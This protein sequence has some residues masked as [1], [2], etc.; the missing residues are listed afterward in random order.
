MAQSDLSGSAEDAAAE[1]AREMDG[2]AARS[3]SVAAAQGVSASARA[4]AR[5]ALPGTRPAPPRPR[6]K[7]PFP[8]SEDGAW[9]AAG[10]GFLTV[11]NYPLRMIRANAAGKAA[12]GL[13]ALLFIVPALIWTGVRAIVGSTW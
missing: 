12:G 13:L 10:E 11:M 5:T 7:N 3:S 4:R 9:V 6:L 1:A 8:R 2:A